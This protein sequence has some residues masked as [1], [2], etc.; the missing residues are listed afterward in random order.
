FAAPVAGRALLGLSARLGAAAVAGCAFLH[1]RNADLRFGA[2]RGLLE[3]EFEVVTQVGAAVHPAAAAGALRAENL[4]EDVAERIGESAE[5][6]GA[7]STR[8]RSGI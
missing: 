6:L 7:E 1:R 3:R 2:A 4:A 5:A 8:A